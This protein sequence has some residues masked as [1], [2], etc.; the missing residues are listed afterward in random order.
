MPHLNVDVKNS[1]VLIVLNKKKWSS[2]VVQSNTRLK[3]I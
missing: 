2:L 3:Y 1:Y